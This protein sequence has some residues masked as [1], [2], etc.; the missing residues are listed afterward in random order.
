[1]SIGFIAPSY[2][3]RLSS[4]FTDLVYLTTMS[5]VSQSMMFISDNPDTFLFA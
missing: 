2:T 1:M 3:L 5:S 4:N